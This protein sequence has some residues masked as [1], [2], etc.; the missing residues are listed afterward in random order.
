MEPTNTPEPIEP[1]NTPLPVV[2]TDTPEPV[3][4]TNTPEPIEPTNTPEPAGP[5][6]TPGPE[7]PTNTPEPVEPTN[8]PEPEEPTATP[9][10]GEPTNTPEPGE[11]TN[12]P[13]PVEPT[14]TP[15]PGE[16]T[17]TPEPV[18]PT[19]VPTSTNTPTPTLT[20]T[21][22][23]TPTNTTTPTPLP[24]V[25]IIHI[26]PVRLEF[27]SSTSSMGNLSQPFAES[28]ETPDINENDFTIAETTADGRILVWG[29][30]S[31]DV[32]FQVLR[33]QI[34][35]NGGEILSLSPEG[36]LLIA[37]A[38]INLPN[39]TSLQV[40]DSVSPFPQREES[41]STS[42][43]E[44]FG[45]GASP[46]TKEEEQFIQDNFDLATEL[47]PNS[48][49]MMRAQLAGEA[50]TPS[51]V[52]N[53]AS[54]FFPPVRSQGGQGSCTCWAACYYYNTF[55]QA[56]DE[57]LNAASGDNDNICSPAFMYPIINGGRDQGAY[58]SEAV[59]RLSEIGCCS[60]S[61]KPYSS[62]DYTSWPSEE[63]WVDALKRRT[64]N[65]YTIYGTSDSGIAAIKQHLANGNIAVTQCPVYTN[66]YYWRDN[67]NRGIQNGVL[68]SHAN[69][70]LVGYHA[71]T[72]VGYDDNRPYNTGSETRYGAF[73]I[74]NSWGSN[75]GTYNSTGTGTRGFM[76]VADVYFKNYF[77]YAFYNDDRD[78]YRPQMFAVNGL[79]H[80]QRGRVAHRGG[81]GNSDEPTWT[82]HYTI[83]YD[84]GSSIAIDDSKPVA[85][86]L[87]EGIS[88]ITNLGTFSLFTQFVLSSG[89]SGNG[90]ISNG[91]FYHDLDGDGTYQSFISE[92]AN[93]NVPPGSSG[94]TAVAI[95]YANDTASFVISNL[96]SVPLA[97]NSISL[98]SEA[99][100]VEWSPAAPFEVA[101]GGS[102]T[103]TV[104]LDW[105]QA[106]DGQST[107]R[108]LVESDDYSG[109]S[110]YAGGVDL[111]MNKIDIPT[112]T[113]SN[114]PLPTNTP[115][116][117][118]TIT[119]IP[120]NTNT[121]TP[122]P[123]VP[124]NTPPEP[125]EPTNTPTPIPVGPTNTPAPNT[126]TPEPVTPTASPTSQPVEPT[127]TPEPSEPTNTPEPAEP[128]NTPEP[129][130][131]T[132]TPTQ[133]PE[134]PTNTPSPEPV[135]PTNTPEP[136]ATST[137]V[138]TSTPEIPTHTPTPTPPQTEHH[139]AFEPLGTSLE[140]HGFS[141]QPADA[142]VT[143]A[144]IPFNQDQPN[145]TNG[146]GLKCLPSQG[147]LLT[148]TGSPITVL[149]NPVSISVW[150]NASAE[151]FQIALGAY[152]EMDN[153][154]GAAGY[155]VR[156]VPEYEPGVWQRTEIVIGNQY[157]RVTPFLVIFN[158]SDSD[159]SIVYADNLYVV[160]G[161][162]LSNG[163]VIEPTEWV[164]NLWLD[165]QEAGNAYQDGDT[166]V[167]E[168]D[169]DKKAARFATY[170]SQGTFPNRVNVEVDMIKD[171]GATGNL[172]LW[173]GNGPSA[174]QSDVPL[175]LLNTGEQETLFL[176]AVTAS[177]PG[178]M[179]I[180]IQIAGQDTERVRITDV[181]IYE[182]ALESTFNQLPEM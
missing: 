35:D 109:N 88:S 65:N 155:T 33:A 130:G 36:K 166:L 4:P 147:E 120:P 110:P 131:P 10:P 84:G 74:T 174:T 101:G 162:A 111:V 113:P 43:T 67:Q 75:W 69:E 96:G 179:N 64:I 78:D 114:T 61:K 62:S 150:Y 133:G 5:T 37:I 90:S 57:N 137:P 106:P 7:E 39:L 56:K 145:A 49:S 160:Q 59:R 129:A 25:P 80:S 68:F 15:E 152:A 92:D 125:V 159:K 79:N 124:T 169:A 158:G 12:T 142:D 83:Q 40:I 156:K 42:P 143:I 167:L 8:T 100:W 93:V 138:V 157:S 85:V 52:D 181:R 86:D 98:D 81:I 170:Y 178:D 41:S 121:P 168:K 1:T 164:P 13:E 95:S 9:E 55:T 11:P 149:E 132:G 60:W 17:N 151:G 118:P 20:H 126:P 2:P 72:I 82:S 71:M 127:N 134:E 47:E 44:D 87:T 19:T 112:P 148:L 30:F 76:W 175:Q 165:P 177:N 182:S 107:S 77:R 154:F 173:I 31:P 32:D 153:Q 29:S 23:L 28:G 24:T 46:P 128:T 26:E 108:L 172:T 123:I 53:S 3:Q 115:S 180:V 73:L 135:E 161:N 51:A 27:Y 48:L 97:V 117:T 141:T 70:S 176:S 94:Y 45:L 140:D 102:Q 122:A 146:V 50:G 21:P 105:D 63:A 91:I 38:E 104:T 66:W 34:L 54:Q 119:P 163:D 14:N 139:Y 136:V 144:E 103:V 89:A 171:S 58:T 16:P 6:N 99:S 22:T 116:N 18:D